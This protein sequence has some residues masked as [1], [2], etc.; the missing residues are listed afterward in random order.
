M[1]A[2]IQTKIDGEMWIASTPHMNGVSATGDTESR[3][4]N[5]LIAELNKLFAAGEVVWDAKAR[6][7]RGK[8]II[9]REISG[10]WPV[11]IKPEA[12][13]QAQELRSNEDE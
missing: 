11:N 3:A 7:K 6:G 9:S 12:P 13:E 5:A 10:L 2:I 1:K 8:D 4:I